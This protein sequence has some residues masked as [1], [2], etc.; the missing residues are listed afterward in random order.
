MVVTAITNGISRCVSVE[1]ASGLDTHYDNWTDEQGPRQRDGFDLIAAMVDDLASRPYKGST[2]E[3]WLDH[4]T[5]VGFSEFS[6][7]PLLNPSTGRD[8]SLTN[9]SFLLG[10]GI[11]G[12]Q[13]IGASS[14]VGMSPQ[15][16]NLETGQVDPGG[17]IIRPEHIHRTLLESLGIFEDIGDLRAPSIPALL[18]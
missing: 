16:V 13:V 3:S 12:G 18:G 1:V 6:R 7:T 11:K 9:A 4:T 5:I 2:S 17:E 8:H 15:N 14:D 10:A